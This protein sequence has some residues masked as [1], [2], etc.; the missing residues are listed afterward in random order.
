MQTQQPPIN[1]TFK[2]IERRKNEWRC[3]LCCHVRTGTIFLG[4]W[5][6]VGEKKMKLFLKLIFIYVFVL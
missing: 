6:L 4:L 2:F 3:L 1:S 5:H